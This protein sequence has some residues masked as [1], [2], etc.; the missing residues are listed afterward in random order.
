[1]IPLFG[2]SNIFKN[3]LDLHLAFMRDVTSDV[4]F[5][6]QL[7][8]K[9]NEKT[10]RRIAEIQC[11]PAYYTFAFSKLGYDCIAVDS[12]LDMLN[13][14]KSLQPEESFPISWEYQSPTH[15]SF[16]PVDICL[17]PLD[18][19]TYFLDDQAQ[20][21]FF[22]S[23][24]S[25]LKKDGL[26]I[27]ELNHPKDIGYI[28]YSVVYPLSQE[29]DPNYQIKVEWGINNPQYDLVTGLA[30]TE[31]RISKTEK[32]K[33]TVEVIPSIERTNFPQSIKLLAKSQGF[34]AIHFLGGYDLAPLSW[35]SNLQVLVFQKISNNSR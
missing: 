28:D 3:P 30:K 32:D 6:E 26:L 29:Y 23:A 14:A 11:G 18:S 34:E 10:A 16:A 7:Y 12:S 17:L 5:V 13:F 4:E 20:S 24:N 19:F 21:D 1:M 15:F 8:F 35:E 25:A 31:I 22:K 2:Y 9:E 27:L 33:K